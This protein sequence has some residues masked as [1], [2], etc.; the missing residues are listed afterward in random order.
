[1]LNRSTGEVRDIWADERLEAISQVSWDKHSTMV[2]EKIDALH[3]T[4]WESV[5]KKEAK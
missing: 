3:I 1:V 2:R 4:G 5:L